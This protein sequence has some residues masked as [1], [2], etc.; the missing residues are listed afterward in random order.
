MV[1]KAK[2]DWNKSL[3]NMYNHRMEVMPKGV[4]SGIYLLLYGDDYFHPE[5]ILLEGRY[6][7]VKE[8]DNDIQVSFKDIDSEDV[9][10]F[11]VIDT[12]NELVESEGALMKEISEFRT[13][14]RYDS[15]ITHE[16]IT[17]KQ[18]AFEKQQREH[19]LQSYFFNQMY[20]NYQAYKEEGLVK[21]FDEGRELKK[22]NLNK[23]LGEIAIDVHNDYEAKKYSSIPK[24]CE[25][26]A[27]HFLSYGKEIKA[28]SL[29]QEVKNYRSSMQYSIKKGIGKK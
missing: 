17:D 9:Y 28:T 23:R 26:Y 15:S 24:A 12:I 4:H 2:G 27:D 25:Y 14:A 6:I 22:V 20:E 7:S 13:L 11:W 21:F 1:K 18:K 3:A 19:T 16:K 8:K 5:K 10:S 29:L